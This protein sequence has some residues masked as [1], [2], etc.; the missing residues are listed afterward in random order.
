MAAGKLDRRIQFR[1][2]TLSDDGFSSALTWDDEQPSNNNL[3][4]PVWGSRADV[5]DGEKWRAGE[6]GAVITS[7]FVVRS[8]TFTRSITAKDR[9]V[10][11][12]R[13]YE[14]TGIKEIGRLDRLEISAAA[15]ADK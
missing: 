12:G 5:S 14:I 6:V 8:S 3:G 10:C 13:E 1:R 2:A 7:R 4:S 9:L 15:R 11:D